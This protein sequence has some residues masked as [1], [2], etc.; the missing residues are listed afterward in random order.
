MPKPDA[1]EGREAEQ[2]KSELVATVSHELRTPLASVLGFVEL[3]LDRDLDADTRRRY[4]ETVHDEAQRL[5][6][7]IDDFLDIEK[8]EAGRFTL[9]LEP[10]ELG[11]LLRHEVELFSAQSVKHTLVLMAPE[12]PLAA[13]GDHNRI[14]QVV[15]NLL[16]NAIKY[17]PAGGPIRIA[18]TSGD[19]FARVEVTDSGLGIPAAQQARVFTKFFR[20]D[21]SDTRKIGGTGL[22]LALCQ[23]IVEAHGGRIGFKSSEGSGSTFWFE[24]PV[25]WVPGTVKPGTRVLLVES[26]D[27]LARALED[28]VTRNGVETESVSTGEL[29]L[30][31]ALARPPSAICLD[32]DLAGDLDG[33]QLLVRLKANPVTARVPVVV[34][35][36][37]A[38][39]TTA[40]TLGAAAFVIT[41]FTAAQLRDA[42]DHVLL[43]DRASVLVVA[44]DHALRRM[45][46]ETLARDGG[47]LLEAADGMEALGLI[48]AR[49]PDALV[50]DLAQP[51][52]NGFGDIRRVLEQP[53][54]QGLPVVVLT[55]RD[56][57]AG[58]RNFLRARNASLLEKS[59][60]SGD[61]LRRLIHHPRF[62]SSSLAA[63][64]MRDLAGDARPP[65]SLARPA[66][67]VASS[68]GGPTERTQSDRRERSHA[69]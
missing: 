50:L 35:S 19:G 66:T 24:L 21:S 10:F 26:D 4:L 23:E 9:A 40:A 30:E 58:E 33:W 41:P 69:D 56:L 43:A 38:R 42:L 48:G 47:E 14:G 13:V 53:E 2:R 11:E 39:R 31:R 15:A 49:H 5:A 34:C 46:V 64:G 20:V 45:V 32:M 25:A 12:L 22:G 17:S 62:A 52:P 3:L 54:T 55:G 36:A 63:L 60:Y 67:V 8:I 59:A 44:G 7:L 65:S 37:A 29:A 27:K 68:A 51:G 1:G 16:S 57:S 28:C 61:Q 6:S 18:A